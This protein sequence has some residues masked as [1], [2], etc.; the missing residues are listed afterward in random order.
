MRFSLKNLGSTPGRNLIARNLTG[1]GG[2]ASEFGNDWHKSHVSE[3]MSL[4][5]VANIFTSAKGANLCYR[6]RNG[7]LSATT[8][9]WPMN[10]RIKDAMVE[11]GRTLVDVTST[12]EQMFGAIP[13]SC[14]TAGASSEQER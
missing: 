10:Q 8:S 5:S 4:D 14:K 12:V 3:G 13:A 7:V 2:A 11:S 6:Y 1:V 9:P